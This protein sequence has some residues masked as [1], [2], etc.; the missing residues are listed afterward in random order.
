MTENT[1]LKVLLVED[2]PGDALLLRKLL[3]ADLPGGF[4]LTHVTRLDEAVQHL[5]YERAEVAL[6]DLNLPDAAGLDVV[7]HIRTA[8]PDLPVV[9]L[10]G[11]ND[12]ALAVQSLQ[13]GAQ[14]YLTKERIDGQLLRRAIRY[15]VE[16]QRIQALVRNLSLLDDL[17]GLHNRRGFLAMAQHNL[18]LA[19]RTQNDFAV[20]FLDLDGMKSINDRLGHSAGNQALVETAQVLQETF[21]ESDVL[22]RLGGDEF[23]AFM[24]QA[25]ADAG[26][27]IRERLRSNLHARNSQ[28][29]RRFPLSFSVGISRGQLDDLRPIEDFLA[30]A[31]A[32]MYEDKRAKRASLSGKT[33]VDETV[34]LSLALN[35]R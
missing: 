31:D 1:P 12:E 15:A 26:E 28:P 6:L 7:R 9:V 29:C 16:R 33:A 21:R 24:L 5:L 2:N 11:M 4:A 22:G 13:E 35:T 34:A 23:A 3:G 27:V 17:T 25:E 18:R 32:L 20:I 8:A 30:A 19:R 10:T 14:D